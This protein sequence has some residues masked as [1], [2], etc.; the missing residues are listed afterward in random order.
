MTDARRQAAADA[1]LRWWHLRRRMNGKFWL[2]MGFLLSLGL[3]AGS[4]YSRVSKSA[5]LQQLE[6]SGRLNRKFVKQVVRRLD[7]AILNTGNLVL[8]P[9][10]GWTQFHEREAARRVEEHQALAD[11][12]SRACGGRR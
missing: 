12:I 4:T 8:P 1:P 2:M 7:R 3:V 5:T 9:Q 6:E 11:L 10:G